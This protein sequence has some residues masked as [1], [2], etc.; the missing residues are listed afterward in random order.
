M[1]NKFAEVSDPNSFVTDP[2]DPIHIIYSPKVLD[3][4]S[5]VLFESG[6]ENIQ[7]LIDSYEDS[8]DISIIMKRLEMGDTSVLS[9]KVPMYGDF[10]QFPKTYA[11]ALQRV[12]DAQNDFDR[13][14][15]DVR[16]SFENDYMRWLAS[17][18]SDDWLEKMKPVLSL[19][20]GVQ[21][22]MPEVLKDE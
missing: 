21:T 14:P 19:Y 11:E 8:C 6:K 13:L 10:T 5:V 4:G 16:N 3:D 17:A 12:I 18:G 15:L 22:A 20:N 9:Q 1:R 2:G 7:D